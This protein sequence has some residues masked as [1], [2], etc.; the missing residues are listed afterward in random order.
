MTTNT[1]VVTREPAP[2]DNACR[3]VGVHADG[4]LKGAARAVERA[5][6]G[7]VSRAV[8][9]GDFAGGIGETL[10]LHD[11]AGTDVAR[12]LLVGLGP[13]PGSPD[14]DGAASDG[15]GTR[16]DEI[17]TAAAK[18]LLATG[19]TS[20][21]SDL[22]AVAADDAHPVPALSARLVRAVANAAWRF[23]GHARRD[24]KDPPAL[25]TLTL[26]VPRDAREASERAVARA[27]AVAHG[28]ARARGLADLAP[29]LC[30]P[31]HLADVARALADEHADLDT[32]VLDEAAMEA[33]GMGAL[34]SVSRGSARPARL[35][36]MAWRGRRRAGPPLVVLGKGITFDTGGISIK[37]S[38]SMDEMKYD[39]GGA[40][41]VFGV[42]DACARLG[43]ELDVVG[44]VAAAENMPDGDS[45]RPGDVVT[46]MS[47]QTIE[48]LNT[49]AEGRLVLADALTWI[50]RE[51][52]PAAVVDVA[53]LTG[54]CVVALGDVASGLFGNDDGLTAELEAAGR[55]SGDLVWP[56]PLLA[57]YQK[58]LDSNFADVA[59][60]GGKGAGAVTAACFLSRFVPA[61]RAWAHVDVAGTAWRGGKDKGATGRPVPLLMQW[62]FDRADRADGGRSPAR[63]SAGATSTVRSKTRSKARPKADR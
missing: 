19:A 59:N 8:S 38:A 63:S 43:L 15:P 1:N 6:D 36:S 45:S 52:S 57:P 12:V 49:D 27:S 48:I 2:G 42:V 46:S 30:T 56:L 32:T 31:E 11:V 51:L 25:E 18:A 22:A 39:M 9:R 24:P 62:L 37:P 53:T 29:N 14:K 35:I 40:A 5:S 20:A 16:W 33:L 3:L 7:A 26:V 61:E 13:R 44:V 58:Q 28:V 17:A 23:D 21:S 34:L 47:G 60:I 10:V 41:A 4:A 50:E 54:A 55:A